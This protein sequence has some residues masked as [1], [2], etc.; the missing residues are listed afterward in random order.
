MQKV[1]NDKVT[2][3]FDGTVEYL[4][5]KNCWLTLNSPENM[6]F[7]A[8]EENQTIATVDDMEWDQYNVNEFTVGFYEQK[9]TIKNSVTE[10]M[11]TYENFFPSRAPFFLYFM[12]SRSVETRKNNQKVLV[13]AEVNQEIK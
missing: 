10:G 7:T 6:I 12:T 5:G 2:I 8:Q 4:A 3:S 9:E 13:S 1:E 11:T